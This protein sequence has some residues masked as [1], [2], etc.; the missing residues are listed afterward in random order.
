MIN[1][2]LPEI[3]HKTPLTS[4]LP[5]TTLHRSIPSNLNNDLG[6]YWDYLGLSHRINPVYLK[7]SSQRSHGRISI[8]S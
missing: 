2:K 6:T 4:E 1:P 7:Q 5:R 3:Y 8:L